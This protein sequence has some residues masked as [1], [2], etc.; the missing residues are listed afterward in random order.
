MNIQTKRI[1]NALGGYMNP[2]TKQDMQNAVQQLREAILG[3]VATRRDLDNN[4]IALQ[5]KTLTIEDMQLALDASRERFIERLGQPFKQQQITNQAMMSQ[6]GT[7]N[8][9]LLDI[10]FQ[11]ASISKMVKSIQQDADILA[12]QPEPEESTLFSQ[13]L[14]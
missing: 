9:R 10:E 4:I 3:Q 2:L 11:I 13:M 6:L 8:R 1:I 5:Q 7:L 12:R 14:S